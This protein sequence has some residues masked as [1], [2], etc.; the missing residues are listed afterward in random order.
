VG[1]KPATT[2]LLSADSATACLVPGC[3]PN[4]SACEPYRALIAEAVSRGRNAMAIWQD[5]VD[6]YG[7]PA[8]YASVRRFVASL[9][10][11]TAPEA[12][13]IITTG[14]GSPVFRPFCGLPRRRCSQQTRRRRPAFSR[15]R[16]DRDRRRQQSHTVNGRSR[17]VR[18]R[19]NRGSAS[20]GES[21]ASIH[22]RRQPV[23]L[24][25]LFCRG[26]QD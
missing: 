1:P 26:I 6:A 3:A 14:C 20:I 2:G 13:V 9:R 15:V 10:G 24:E 11:T 17:P 12:R 25:F 8:R 7:F 18:E 22:S 23:R 19:T 5:L 21:A 4:A 16:A